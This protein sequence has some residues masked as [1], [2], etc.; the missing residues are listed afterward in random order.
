MAEVSAEFVEIVQLVELRRDLRMPVS[1]VSDTFSFCVVASDHS[2]NLLRRSLI[3][4]MASW[5]N[6][7]SGD[8]NA[9]PRA[10][11]NCMTCLPYPDIK[12][13]EG[14]SNSTIVS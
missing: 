6:L 9:T 13:E 2:A 1:Q 11:D 14:W 8:N 7:E 12:R 3:S 10:T 5:V 4:L